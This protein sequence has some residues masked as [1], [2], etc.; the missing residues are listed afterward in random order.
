MT[1]LERKEKNKTINSYKEL[2]T[3]PSAKKLKDEFIAV[4]LS[5]SK[6][7]PD[8]GRLNVKMI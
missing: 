6:S 8:W 2:K 5:Y 4:I 3:T 1:L 7:L